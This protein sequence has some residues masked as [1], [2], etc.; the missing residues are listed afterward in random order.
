MIR[1]NHANSA[2]KSR[3]VDLRHYPSAMFLSNIILVAAITKL[4]KGE[5]AG[6]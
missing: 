2:G 5:I 4:A 1:A 6:Y 3:A